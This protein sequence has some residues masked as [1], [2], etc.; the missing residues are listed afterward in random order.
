[1][2]HYLEINYYRRTKSEKKP[3]KQHLLKATFLNFENKIAICLYNPPYSKNVKS[4][5]GR[6]FLRLLDT[7]FSPTNPLHKLFMRQ[8][9][10]ISYRCMPNMAQ[11]IARHNMK[12]IFF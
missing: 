7:A 1:M 2:E 12:V 3:Y 11:A 4:N 5:I 9:V 8:T 10:K 6:D